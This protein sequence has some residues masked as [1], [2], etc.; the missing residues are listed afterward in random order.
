MSLDPLLGPRPVRVRTAGAAALAA[1]H[2]GVAVPPAR[3]GQ[4]EGVPRT[5]LEVVARPSRRAR[6]R[7]VAGVA[8]VAAA[9]TV[10]TL[11]ALAVFQAALVQGQGR[12]DRLQ[13]D[14]AAEQ[15]RHERLVFGVA[16]QE[17]PDRILAVALERLGMVAPQKVTYLTPTAEQARAVGAPAG[18]QP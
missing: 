3:P 8:T 13:R 14:L 17:A 11:F 16:A 10:V 7:R 18:P 12:L 5:P 15:S 1:S 9:L 4:R 2:P 6:R